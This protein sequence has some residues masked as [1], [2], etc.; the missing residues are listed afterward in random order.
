MRTARGFG[1]GLIAASLAAALAVAGCGERDGG[2]GPVKTIAFSILSSQAQAVAEPL[3]APLL[4]DLSRAADVTVTPRFGASYAAGVED[5][6]AGRV[7]V[8]WF[9]AQPAV[10]ALDDGD[11]E[12]I[13]RTVS[14]GGADSYRS[15]LVARKGSGV[16]LETLLTCDR[17]LSLGMG[18]PASTSGALAPL[19]FLFMPRDIRPEACF[20]RISVSDRD[21]HLFQVA[22]GALDVAAANDVALRVLAQQN[23]QLAAQL[24][25]V[26]ISPPIPEGGILVRS[27][28]DP[29]LKE[30]I[31][32]FFL[33]YSERSGA[34]GDRQR[35]VLAGLGWSRFVAAE[36]T[37]LD[38]VREMMAARDEAEAR[39]KGDRAAARAAAEKR[40]TLQA[41][42][43][44]RP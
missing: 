35:Q 44:V 14:T 30:K 33:S 41:R 12:L 26:W 2:T 37:Y 36:E 39:A 17:S 4:E 1:F 40:R 6:R 5:L 24:E 3:W 31:R 20:K 13:A 32:S 43:E 28:L 10:Q 16:T 42:R 11:A 19:A 18:D 15:V 23:P 27:D 34:A 38:P 22:T 25:P 21:Q 9:S 7:Q 29:V 8:G